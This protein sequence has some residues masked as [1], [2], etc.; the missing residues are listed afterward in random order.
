MKL[1]EL[2]T[3]KVLAVDTVNRFFNYSHWKRTWD[4]VSH[5]VDGKKVVIG[6]DDK[7]YLKE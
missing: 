5:E 3:V 4:L 1:I 2:S 6:G 7:L